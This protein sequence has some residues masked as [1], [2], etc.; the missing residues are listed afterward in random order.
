M[1]LS[2]PFS[3]LFRV[4]ICFNCFTKQYCSLR[5]V[6][7]P[8]NVVVCNDFMVKVMFFKFYTSYF[9]TISVDEGVIGQCC[10]HFLVLNFDEESCVQFSPFSCRSCLVSENQELVEWNSGHKFSCAT[11]LNNVAAEKQQGFFF[12][13]KVLYL[14]YAFAKLH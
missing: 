7:E 6:F 4:D 8:Y 5:L 12:C 11:V 2:F 1:A 9:P 13:H 3:V 10:L 14:S